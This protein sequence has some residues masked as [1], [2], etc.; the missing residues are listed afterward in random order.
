MIS[1]RRLGLLSAGSLLSGLVLPRR[2]HAAAP[3]D[4]ER[5]FLFVLCYGGWDT[6]FTFTPMF[7]N[8]AA[9]VEPDATTA[10]ASGITFVDSGA[11]PSVRRF[12]EDY[13]SQCCVINGLEVPSITHERCRRIVM[14][15][16]TST[17]ADGWPAI[18]AGHAAGD[19]LLPHVVLAGPAYTWQY[20]SAVVRVGNNGQLPALMDGTALAQSDQA[21][22]G[23]PP[24]VAA[25]G[26][27]FLQGRVDEQAAAAAGRAQQV[28]SGYQGALS[29]LQSLSDLDGVELSPEDAGC[30]RNLSNDA[31]AI[32]DLFA[33]GIARCAMVRNDGWCS[34]TWDTHQDNPL[35]S[36][37]FEELFG[38]LSTLMADLNSRTALSG[39][40][41]SEE[42]TVVVLSEMGRHPQM[43]TWGGKDHW[44]FTSAMLIGAG[45][46]GGQ[47]IGALDDDA[48]GRS[49]DLSSGEVTDSGSALT[50]AHLGATV[51]AMGDVDPGDFL[52]AEPI[53]AAML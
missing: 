16:S 4:S 22:S 20:S 36:I 33:L 8:A 35:Q 26:E 43:N 32:F 31:A 9:D 19:L 10:A 2:L 21:V 29:Q 42:V 37:H 17:A 53:T 41:L 45:V 13:G 48:L 47:V 6:S 7:D 5:K 3:G 27:A 15:G 52:D 14:T 50:S 46:S 44:T 28:L 49:I 24:E 40:P 51:L 18:L 39:R 38:Y 30:A 23:L 34:Q 25:L 1:R 11:R 12:F